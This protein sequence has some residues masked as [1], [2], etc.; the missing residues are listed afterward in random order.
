LSSGDRE[1]TTTSYA[2]LGLLAIRP[3]STYELARQMRR[4]LHYFWPRAESNLYAEPKRLV[5]GGLAEAHAEPV[6]KRRR[7]VYSITQKGQRALESWLGKPAAETRLESE[8]LVKFMFAPYGSKQNLLDHLRRFVAELEARQEALRLIFREYLDGKDA[9]PERVHVNVLCYRL[10]W[11]QT[12]TAASWAAWAIDLVE[13]WADVATATN[14]QELM[15]VLERALK[16]DAAEHAR[17]TSA[18]P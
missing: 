17:S 13:Q 11:D 2:I 4:N 12:A 7:T 9:F 3:W 10:I 14:R 18:R 6:G 15:N 8:T 5:E 1:L 16:T